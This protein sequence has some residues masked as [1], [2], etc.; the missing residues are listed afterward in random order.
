MRH[1]SKEH[2][3]IACSMRAARLAAE[4]DTGTKRHAELAP[5][6]HLLLRDEAQ[7]LV[8]IG[9]R[10]EVA[11]DQVDDRL[12]NAV[13]LPRLYVAHLGTYVSRHATIAG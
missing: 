7:A 11:V 13:S 12:D 3:C 6:S 4:T 8:K 1:E 2:V 10:H 5:S 9:Q